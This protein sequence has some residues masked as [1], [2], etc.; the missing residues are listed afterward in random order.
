MKNW[1]YLFLVEGGGG[2]NKEGC[3]IY[4]SLQ[5]WGGLLERGLIRE[6]SFIDK[7]QYLYGTILQ[8]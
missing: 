3:L 8:F 6:G 1:T 2:G 5:K 7:L 4:L